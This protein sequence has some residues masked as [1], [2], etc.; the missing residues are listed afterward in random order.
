MGLAFGSRSEGLGSFSQ[1][2]KYEVG[3]GTRIRFWKDLWCGESTLQEAFP[4]LY[5]IARDKDALVSVHF[6]VR[7]DQIHWSLDFVRAAQD[8]ELESI[9]SFLDLLYST[10]VRGSGADMLWLH[11]P[12]KG[13][14]VR[15]FYRVLSRIGGCSFPGKAFGSLRFPQ[16]S[17]SLF[18]LLPLG[19]F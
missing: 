4:E 15:S 12:Q 3:D 16:G 14:T 2:V 10:K 17:L 7:N 1:H 5:R 13:F 8:W 11:S 19:K 18:G 9:A 6:Q